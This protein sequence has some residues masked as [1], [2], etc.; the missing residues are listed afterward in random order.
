MRNNEFMQVKPEELNKADLRTFL[1]HIK[2]ST[3]ISK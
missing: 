2:S 3:G 1:E